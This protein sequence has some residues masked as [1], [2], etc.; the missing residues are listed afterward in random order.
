MK[1]KSQEIRV[2]APYKYSIA[3]PGAALVGPHHFAFRPIDDTHD[4]LI[5]PRIMKGKMTVHGNGNVEFVENSRLA[6]AKNPLMLPIS[7]DNLEGW[8][9]KRSTQNYIMQIKLPIG[10]TRQEMQR[11]IQRMMP[12]ILGEITVDQQELLGEEPFKIA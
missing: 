1:K 2:E 7:E 11:R 10:L 4:E 9:L 3:V 8:K 6:D 12:Q 5:T